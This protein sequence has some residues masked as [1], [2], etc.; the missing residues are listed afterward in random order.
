M[1]Q[2]WQDLARA[3][4][5]NDGLR[6]VSAVLGALLGLMR[7]YASRPKAVAKRMESVPPTDLS[8]AVKEVTGQHKALDAR[9]TT[10][11]REIA[12]A[13]EAWTIEDLRERLKENG[14]DLSKMACALAV[15]R[16]DKA[17]L[18]QSI[19]RKNA[20]IAAIKKRLISEQVKCQT[21]QRALEER[22]ELMGQ[23]LREIAR[24]EREV[25]V[26]TRQRDTAEPDTKITPIRP[27]PLP[28]K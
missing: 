3:F 12:M 21:L 18:E 11:E 1:H 13:R 24:L 4:A 7:L 19:D 17:A 26:L 6:I 10:I 28:R 23:H 15:E 22:D 8:A 14:A 5:A 25:A 16:Q 20:E 2:L 9:M 27:P